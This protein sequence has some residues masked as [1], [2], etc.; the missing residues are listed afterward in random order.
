MSATMEDN[1]FAQYF[2]CPRMTTEGKMFPVEVFY[3]ED[4]YERIQYKYV[5]F[6]EIHNL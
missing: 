1:L 5:P 4:V 6:T 2:A 3:L